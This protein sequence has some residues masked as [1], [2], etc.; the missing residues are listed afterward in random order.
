MSANF[1][2]PVASAAAAIVTPEVAPSPSATPELSILEKIRAATDKSATVAEKTGE[3]AAIP[4]VQ[5]VKSG[6]LPESTAEAQA[7]TDT[8]PP[9]VD[10]AVVAE[11]A[12][13]S[14]R[15]AIKSSNLPTTAKAEISDL[16]YTG[17]AF[18]E[19]GYSIEELRTLKEQ[20]VTAESLS[21]RTALH[22]TFEAEEADAN[23]AGEHRMLI[24]DLRE[25]PD[26]FLEK[27]WAAS[28]EVATNLIKKAAD[29]L[30]Y[31]AKEDVQRQNANSFRSTL[32]KINAAGVQNNNLNLQEAARIIN[33]H[34]FGVAVGAAPR[35]T[36]N[37]QDPMH[38]ELQA[39]KAERAQE[40]ANRQR[41]DQAARSQFMDH[42]GKT[43]EQA[44]FQEVSSRIA[45][46]TP[47]WDQ[48][49]R[50]TAVNEVFTQVRQNLYG[51]KNVINDLRSIASQGPMSQETVD[52]AIKHV[53]ANSQAYIVNPL[54]KA[55]ATW[56]KYKLG[57]DKAREQI[58]SKTVGK[59]DVGQVGGMATPAVSAMSP[60][61]QALA[62]GK[63]NGWGMN[64]I[65]QRKL[66]L[67]AQKR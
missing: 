27:I 26:V 23:L 44:I 34:V 67:M 4:E 33:E 8:V 38:R 20:G 22:P 16:A 9:V 15:Q 19:L 56:G 60:G 45:K 25:N 3:P 66:E 24:T 31:V 5:D 40:Q 64:E 30:G 55:L 47:T 65:L 17:K 63:K 62:E 59:P 61:Q 57:E 46:A 29:K 11:Q 53:L 51:N 28:P 21:K 1:E 32:A 52:R 12:A 14:L 49:L 6:Q 36:I 13:E 10:P 2:A 48:N 54:T 37:P 43:G 35:A 50:D 7:A 39:L 42:V 58:Q 41:Q 18:K